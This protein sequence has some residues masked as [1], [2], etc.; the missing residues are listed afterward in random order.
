MRYPYHDASTGQFEALVVELCVYLL[1]EGTHGFSTG[2]DEGRDARFEGTAARFPSTAK[3]LDGKFVIQ[4]KHTESPIA[5]FSDS[6]FSGDA[7]SSMISKEVDRVC[8]LRQMDECDHYFLFSNRRLSGQTEREIR[9]DIRAS[10][11]VETVELFGIERIDQILHRLPNA[12]DNA[13]L[14]EL[15][16]PLRVSPDDLA[17]VICALDRQRETFAHAGSSEDILRTPFEEKNR[18]NRMRDE[19]AKEIKRT[20]M[21]NFKGVS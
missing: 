6:D 17:E 13:G 1:G 4:A 19:F 5:K 18:I 15:K 8:T 9:N 7:A 20:Y 16:S 14:S 3:P 11:G 10:T 12:L 2:P 21:R